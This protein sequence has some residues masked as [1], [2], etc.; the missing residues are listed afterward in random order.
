MSIYTKTSLKSVKK[1]DLVEMYLE[2]QGKYNDV[3]MDVDESQE[4][5]KLREDLR[6]HKVAYNGAS[7]ERNEVKKENDKLKKT[8]EKLMNDDD[9]HREKW[10]KSRAYGIK[11]EKENEKLKAELYR[12][13][14]QYECNDNQIV[15]H[16]QKEEIEKL[17]KDIRH[18][19]LAYRGADEENEKLKEE[20]EKLNDDDWVIDCHKALKYKIVLTEDHYAELLANQN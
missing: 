4:I 12:P 13:C 8:Q 16:K 10:I 11:L 2:L 7:E 17:E 5:K 19:K 18:H 15:I 20:N 14:G 1:E 3:Q 6:K 9:M